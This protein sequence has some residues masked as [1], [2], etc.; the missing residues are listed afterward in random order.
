MVRRPGHGVR[1]TV[2]LA[3]TPLVLLVVVGLGV[4]VQ[5]AVR[6]ECST[7]RALLGV[8]AYPATQL[9]GPAAGLGPVRRARRPTRSA[10]WKAQAYLA[11]RFLLGLPLAVAVL[12][13]FGG[14]LFLI[15][16]PI[17]YRWI[18]QADGAHGFDFGIWQAESLGEA[19]LLVPAGLVL[20]V[21]AAIS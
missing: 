6:A 18:P 8:P 21:L 9:A 1:S 17:H 7:V 12:S 3:V 14:A 11:L 15:T 4:F 20:L 10:F 16:G 13:L 19:L 2:A 5:L